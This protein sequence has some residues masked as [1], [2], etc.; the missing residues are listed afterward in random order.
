MLVNFSFSFFPKV[1]FS[2]LSLIFEWRFLLK[3]SFLS[4]CLDGFG[5]VLYKICP[6]IWGSVECSNHQPG[7]HLY[8]PCPC[9][10][11]FHV[12]YASQVFNNDNSTNIITNNSMKTRSHELDTQL[13]FILSFHESKKSTSTNPKE[14]RARYPHPLY[15]FI[16]PRKKQKVQHGE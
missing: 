15:C 10:S 12:S 7:I 5:M 3:H 13:F 16:S 14:I 11:N 6:P 4:L 9:M 1:K 8:H 2:P